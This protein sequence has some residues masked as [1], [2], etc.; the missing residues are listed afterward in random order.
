MFEDLPRRVARQ[1]ARWAKSPN[2]VFDESPAL[3]TS[4]DLLDKKTL[5]ISFSDDDLAPH[6]AVLDLKRFYSRLK[7]DHRHYKPEDVL[8]KRVGHFGFFKKRIES[9]LWKEIEMWIR[10][11]L[12]ERT[13]RA[14]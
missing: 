2:Y 12:P 14:A 1:W 10:N 3:K 4:F 7:I 6:R 8:Q 9:T 13:H 5:M 11:C